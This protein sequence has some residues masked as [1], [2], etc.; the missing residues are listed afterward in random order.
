MLAKTI[1]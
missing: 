1:Q